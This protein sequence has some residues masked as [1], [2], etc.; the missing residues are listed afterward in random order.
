MGEHARAPMV[1]QSSAA[2]RVCLHG[3]AYCPCRAAP[4]LPTAYCSLWRLL[5]IMHGVAEAMEL[6]HEQELERHHRLVHG[7]QKASGP[8]RQRFPL[9]AWSWAPG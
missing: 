8:P 4:H 1:G 3:S 7:L 5:R 9:A 2:A 6:N